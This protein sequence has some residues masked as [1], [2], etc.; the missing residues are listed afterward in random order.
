MAIGASWAGVRSMVGTSGGGFALMNEGLGLAAMSETPL[1]I[2]ESQRPGPSTGMS[3]WTEQGDLQYLAKAGH[4]EFHRI[5]LAPADA[6][7]SFYFTILAFNLADIYQLPVFVLLDKYISE[8]HQVISKFKL[9][10]IKIN[11]GKI[12]NKNQLAK[13]EDYKRYSLT[14]DGISPRSLPGQKNGIFLAN[15]NEHDEY[16][17]SIDG[18]KSKIREEQ[19]QKRYA[20]LKNI[21]KDL[22]KSVLFGPANAQLTLVGWGSTK[23]ITLEALKILNQNSNKVNYIHIPAPF[24][25]NTKVL[26]G[27]LNKT[28]KIVVIENNYIGQMAN[29]MQETLGQKFEN[30]LN[31]Y[32]GQQFFPEEIVQKIKKYEK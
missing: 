16:G 19:M 1:V 5:I 18:F 27:L 10:N 24:P 31:K 15:G 13:I 29:L 3:T 8:S 28:K 25:L 6:E 32:N 14:K 12:L 4:G 9:D 2:V 30:R 7:E 23:E 11:R 20:K 21:L 26:S 17:F 22:P